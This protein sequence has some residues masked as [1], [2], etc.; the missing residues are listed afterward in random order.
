MSQH[1]IQAKYN[2][3]F[4]KGQNK[5]F[6]KQITCI[7]NKLYV[8]AFRFF[9]QSPLIQTTMYTSDSALHQCYLL[10]RQRVG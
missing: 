7:F 1:L 4:Q 10:N 5:F 3:P 8:Y 6:H 2:T 9:L